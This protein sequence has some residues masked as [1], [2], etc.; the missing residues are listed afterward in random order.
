M[1]MRTPELTRF[2]HG[3][4]PK[5]GRFNCRRSRVVQGFEFGEARLA[6]CPVCTEYHPV[7][8]GKWEKEEKE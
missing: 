6:L 3:T 7:E 2:Y 4:C 1:E 8:P 5:K